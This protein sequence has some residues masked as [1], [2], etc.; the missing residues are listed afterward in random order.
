MT[1]LATEARTDSP[2]V[3]LLVGNNNSITLLEPQRQKKKKNAIKAG[4]WPASKEQLITK[5]RDSFLTFLESIDF[6]NL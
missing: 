5:H 4:H 2:Q 6:D 3:I 1:V